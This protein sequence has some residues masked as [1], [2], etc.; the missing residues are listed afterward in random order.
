MCSH[1][2][3]MFRFFFRRFVCIGCHLLKQI[4]NFGWAK[5]TSRSEFLNIAR[6]FTLPVENLLCGDLIARR[7]FKV[8][9]PSFE[10]SFNFSC[11][12]NLRNSLKLV[13]QTLITTL[14]FFRCNFASAKIYH[15]SG[16]LL[17]A[18]MILNYIIFCGI[19]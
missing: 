3:E 11:R 14:C 6:D 2:Y 5:S 8:A 12:C 10:P 19:R 17:H 16:D 1:V 4:W 13:Y 18:T 9:T 15:S 7:S